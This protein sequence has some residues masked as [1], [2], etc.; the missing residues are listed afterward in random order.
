MIEVKLMKKRLL[1]QILVL[2]M[3]FS[4]LPIEAWAAIEV[5]FYPYF[6]DVSS[7]GRISADKTLT[8]IATSSDLRITAMS[9]RAI[10]VDSGKAAIPEASGVIQSL[11]MDEEGVY[12]YKQD[13]VLAGDLAITG[14]KWT[15]E[16]TSEYKPIKGGV[17]ADTVVQTLPSD[18]DK[19]YWYK[20]YTIVD[21]ADSPNPS[22]PKPDASAAPGAAKY[23]AGSS[24]LVLRPGGGPGAGELAAVNPGGALVEPA[25]CVVDSS[26][27]PLT[28]GPVPM[29]QAV[30]S[31]ANGDGAWSLS[32]ETTR[33]FSNSSGGIQATFPKLRP[34][35]KTGEAFPN[36]RVKF[37][38]GEQIIEY[39]GGPAFHIPGARITVSS[40]EVDAGET[41]ELR[42][43][44]A[45]DLN[46]Q[47]LTGFKTIA[48]TDATDGVSRHIF[49]GGAIFT[50]GAA[51]I[52]LPDG[53]FTRDTVG[54]RSLEIEVGDIFQILC[55][56]L[57][58]KAPP[59]AGP[60]I[61]GGDISMN[62]IAYVRNGA[63]VA[64]I[65]AGD[66]QDAV[67]QAILSGSA[68]LTVQVDVPG[69]A[70]VDSV[71]ANLPASAVGELSRC[72]NASLT[73]EPP[74]AAVVIPSGS[75]YQMDLHTGDLAVRAAAL[76]PSTVQI[77]LLYDDR[78]V[79]GL[80]AG[81][82]VEI[83]V[84][85]I[86]RTSGVAAWLV[87]QNGVQTILPKSVV[88]NSGD[89]AVLLDSGS[90]AITYQDGS[91]HFSDVD[92][93]H[94]A[95]DA[96]A[97]VSGHGLFQGTTSTTFSSSTVMNRAMLATVLHR[98]EGAPYVVGDSFADVPAGSYYEQAAV[99]AAGMGIVRG[100][101]TGFNGDRAVTRQEMAVMLYRY[102]Q[103]THISKGQLGSYRGM[104][105]AD[106]VAD[107]ADEAMRW[108]VGSGIIQGSNGNL[109][110]R[111]N[112]TR[113]EVAQMMSNF[114]R[115]ITQ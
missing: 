54:S 56:T 20:Y 28:S 14:G 89:L 88:N 78:P 48:V 47:T 90:A 66:L 60:P 99:W 114:V 93:S 71:Q 81:M 58:V 57:T 38:V 97:F 103:A 52:P 62:S 73:V 75:L 59:S 94:W 82:R 109:T 83:P 84:R 31:A 17:R 29:E 112:A 61:P 30:I 23:R 72:T 1:V 3:V 77:A 13:F 18:F 50:N 26:G 16:V 63:A 46:Y 107:W 115:L 111:S 74:L 105:G 100:D 92:S 5:T 15:F 32:G 10:H 9:L 69:G 44:Q 6:E 8:V 64:E 49:R 98:L 37:T 85:R 79:G 19:V 45:R 51:T 113:A 108:A 106:Q 42:I 91:R 12:T 25:V 110:P 68:D 53:A 96:I 11:P 76:D 86:P 4:M 87:N 21:G 27:A 22:E 33:P 2:C 102:V 41:V 24:G 80:S 7:D 34:Y 95:A 70:P 39:D 101:G 40:S 35:T 67:N 65:D 36:A 104:G 55:T 43:T